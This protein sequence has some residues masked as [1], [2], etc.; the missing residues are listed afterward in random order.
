MTETRSLSAALQHLG[1]TVS[2]GDLAGLSDAELLGRFAGRRDEAAFT[3]LVRRYSAV[4]FGVCRRVLRHEQDAEDAF[5]ATFLVLAKK[6]SGVG[7]A[8]AVGNWLYGV[9]F[10]VARHAKA[11]RHRRGVK[12]KT[13][14]ER[15]PSDTCDSLPDDLR[16][17]VDAELHA[18]PDRYRTAVVLCDMMGLTTGEAAAEVGCPPKTLGTRLSRGRTAL[19]RRLT[20]RGVAAPTAALTTVVGPTAAVAVPP[21]LIGST[22]Q[23]S[24][25]AAAAPVAVAALTKGVSNVMLPNALKSAAVLACGVLVL[26]GVAHGPGRHGV[27][28]ASGA[29]AAAARSAGTDAPA[30][31]RHAMDHHDHLHFLIHHLLD[32]VG[33]GPSETAE[34]SASPAEDKKDDKNK[35][36]LS[37][38]WVRSSDGH[39]FKVEFSDKDVL[40]LSAFHGEKG[41]VITCKYTVEKNEPVRAKITEIEEKGIAVKETLPVGSTFSFKWKVN[42]ASATLDD[43]KGDHVELLKSHLEGQFDQKK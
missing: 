26:A 23:T 27:S 14:A 24:T 37:G 16:E 5:Q 11:A 13:A 3:A 35:P 29:P 1:R 40:K 22:V 32:V 9:A 15:R 25:G 34:A 33:F 7:R 12:E 2:A 6:A 38:T 21:R 42:G 17:V 4:V 28:A 10:N 30:A 39:E 18:L 36:A 19:A 43:I 20:R 41:V 31:P 8:G